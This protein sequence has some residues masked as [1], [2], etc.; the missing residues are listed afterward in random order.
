MQGMLDAMVE[1]AGLTPG[2]DNWE[3]FLDILRSDDEGH[4]LNLKSFQ[5]TKEKTPVIFHA[6][7]PSPKYRSTD[8][9]KEKWM[10]QVRLDGLT[11]FSH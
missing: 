7:V 2:D 10:R 8:N 6:M 9:E 1:K 4:T 3:G 11:V 5:P